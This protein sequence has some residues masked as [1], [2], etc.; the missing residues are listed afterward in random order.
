M[1]LHLKDELA[2]AGSETGPSIVKQ[3]KTRY[4]LLW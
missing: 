4:N 3:K 2:A 1:H